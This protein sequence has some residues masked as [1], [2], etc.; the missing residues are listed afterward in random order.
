MLKLPPTSTVSSSL[1]WLA[2]GL[3]LIVLGTGFLSQVELTTTEPSESSF[4][5]NSIS[6]KQIA[7]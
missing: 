6:T 4:Q 7:P 3:V 1:L 5:I 2:T